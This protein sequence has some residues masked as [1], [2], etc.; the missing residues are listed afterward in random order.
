MQK[1]ERSLFRD[2]RHDLTADC[3][4]TAFGNKGPRLNHLRRLQSGLAQLA[5]NT[6]AHSTPCT[7]YRYHEPTGIFKL[8]AKFGEGLRLVEQ[9]PI[10]K[11]KARSGVVEYGEQTVPR[12]LQNGADDFGLARAPR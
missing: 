1:S 8:R 6:A 11:A 12:R 4:T 5:S 9:R 2:R 7:I 3:N 10:G